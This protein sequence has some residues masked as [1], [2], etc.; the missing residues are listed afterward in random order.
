M[1]YLSIIESFYPSF[2]KQE[3]KV[4]DF[5]LK[6]KD[7][8]SFMPLHEI[9]KKIKVSEATIFRFVKKIGFKGFIEFKLEVAR[10]ISSDE[11][12][13]GEDYIENI[14]TNILETVKSTR[15]LLKKEDVEKAIEYIDKSDKMYIFGLGSSGV[16]AL[17]MQNRFMRFGKIGHSVNDGHFQV[18]YSSTVTKKD[19]IIV[20]SLS[21]ETIDLIYPLTIAKKNGA[22]I[23]TITNYIMSPIAKMS[24]LVLLTSGKENLLDGGALISKISQLYVIDVIATGYAL[25]NKTTA[26]KMKEI[27][28]EAIANKSK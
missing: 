1:K 11:K 17:E 13:M 26:V 25:K 23:I 7:G 14:E 21:G 2:S 18:M 6:E 5:I 22:K 15:S 10:E 4:A 8:V 16:A 28:A 3:K 27:I 12:D 19:V 20:I 9:T 24:D